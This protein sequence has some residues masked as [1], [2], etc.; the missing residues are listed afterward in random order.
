MR[1]SYNRAYRAPSMVNNSLD[2]TVATALPLGLINP[3]FGN[4]IFY[5]PTTR[6]GI[7]I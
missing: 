2:T 5:V 7:P 4:Q 1:L 6:R 3:A